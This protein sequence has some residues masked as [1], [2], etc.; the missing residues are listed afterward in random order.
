[1]H[2]KTD[3]F[4]DNASKG[5]KKAVLRVLQ[6]NR[7]LKGQKKEELKGVQFDIN[8]THS[9]LGSTALQAAATFGREEVVDILLKHGAD[10]NARRLKTEETALHLAAGAGRVAVV[11]KLLSVGANKHVVNRKGET[12]VRFRVSPMPS[13]NN[14]ATS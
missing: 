14:I 12:P 11:H 8:G 10:A 13:A 4:I 1:M 5:R 9:I 6:G 3:A 7:R 2:H